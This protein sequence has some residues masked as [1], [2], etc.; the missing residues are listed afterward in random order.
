MMSNALV[1]KSMSTFTAKQLEASDI[2]SVVV[3][4]LQGFNDS[5]FAEQDWMNLLQQSNTNT[6]NL[7][8]KW[9]RMWWESFGKGELL[10]L[11]AEKNGE[12]VAL[13]PFFT[14]SGMIY[15]LCPEDSLDIIG[16]ITDP[17]I[18]DALLIS[19]RKKVQDFAGFL[20]YFIPETSKTGLRLKESAKRLGL[21]FAEQGNIPSPYIDLKMHPE[22]VVQLTRK[23]S[24]R[25]HEN[26]FLKNGDLRVFHFKKAKDILS[27]L[28]NFFEQHIQR[29]SATHAQSIFKDVRQREYY[30]KL[31]KELDQ[32]GWLRFTIV[33]WNGK[34]IAYHYGLSYE[35]RYLFGIPSFEIELAM[36]SPGEVLLKHLITAAIDE[37]ASTFDFGIG[38]EPYKY[39]FATNT[40]YLHHFGLYPL[41]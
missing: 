31:T 36:H 29:R 25:R 10:L 32:S 13:A 14:K 40:T 30:R 11:L 33:Q 4:K 7:T 5:Y 26:Y 6:V 17:E 16:D 1:E 39:R 8:W 9:Q 15:N 38:E 34:P 19:A 21:H 37:N 20:F 18:L 41:K 27:N 3:K 12:P 24:L 35:G 28:E 2:S 23:K 22:K